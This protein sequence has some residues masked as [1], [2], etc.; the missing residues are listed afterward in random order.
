MQ[1]KQFLYD[2]LLLH[3]SQLERED[4]ECYAWQTA[5]LLDETSDNLTAAA[6]YGQQMERYLKEHGLYEDFLGVGEEAD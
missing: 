3:R 2:V 6:G 1:D 5:L 4:L